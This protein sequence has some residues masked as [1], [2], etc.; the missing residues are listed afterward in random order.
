MCSSDL[1]SWAQVASG[2]TYSLATRAD[3]SLFTWGGNSV[4][5]LGILDLAHRSSPVQIGTSSWTNISANTSTT[6]AIRNDYALFMWGQGTNYN[7]GNLKLLNYSSPVA[8][9]NINDSWSNVSSGISYH[10]ALRSD[11]LLFTFGGNTWGT[12]GTNDTLHRKIGR[13]HV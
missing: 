3:K 6:M 10:L 13:A 4:G 12:L 2:V 7:F 1:S 11:R 5:Q 8:L 9:A